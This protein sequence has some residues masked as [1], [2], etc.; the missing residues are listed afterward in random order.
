MDGECSNF[1]HDYSDSCH[2]K[3]YTSIS[4]KDLEKEYNED[5]DWVQL[6]E[7][8]SQPSSS[9]TEVPYDLEQLGTYIENYHSITLVEQCDGVIDVPHRQ[10]CTLVLCNLG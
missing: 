5:L 6:I 7:E 8:R 2:S 10:M 3:P 4:N 1:P 9:H